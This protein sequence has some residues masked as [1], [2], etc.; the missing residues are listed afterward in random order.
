MTARATSAVALLLAIG[1]ISCTRN[2][3]I[4]NGRHS[5]SIPGTL[6]IAVSEEP[7]NVNPLLAGTTVEGFIDRFMFEPLLSADARGNAVPM[8]AVTVPTQENGGISRDGLTIR[9]H[10]RG[11]ARW[12]DGVP[13]TARDVIS[14]WHAILNPNNDVVSRHGYDDIASIDA[15]D[16]H[17]AVVHLKRPFAPFVNTFFA[18][19]DQ[20]YNVAPAHVFAHYPDINRIGF[21]SAPSVS[22]G[23]FLFGSWKRGDRILLAA[24]PKFFMGTPRLRSIVIQFVPNE[25]SAVNLLRTHAV[26]FVHEPSFQIYPAL[27]SIPDT[28]IIGVNINGYEGLMFNMS[29]PVPA[30]PLVR[31][32][33]AAAI[34]KNSLAQQLTHGQAMVATEDLP[35]W[36]WAFDPSVRSVPFDPAVATKLLQQAGWNPGSDGLVRKHGRAM[37]LLLATD[38]QTAI[39]RSESVLIQAALHRIGISVEVKYYPIQLL[40]A[41]QALGGIMHGGKF[42]LLL[43]PWISGIDPDNSSQF[44]C[45]NAPPHGYNDSHYCSA[46]MDSA[47]IDALRHY[48]QVDRKLAYSKIERLLANDNPLV[49]FWWQRTLQA[50]SVDF[51]GFDPNPTV[52]SWDAWRWNI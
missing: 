19:S 40:Y 15:P 9:Y 26:D 10:L 8:L 4:V 2:G 30:N 50:V 39:H 31:R 7:K 6:R 25:D 17:T 38:T 12:S 32:A 20:P 3:G 11:N 52:E 28:K 46:A 43:Y 37:Q 5:W 13:V 18:E 35:S 44:T 24:N 21:N 45:A 49:F 14:S 34:D 36:L 42:D 23:P 22:D 27:H 1:M 41:P 33:I 48:D 16:A 47:Q 29:H 51:H